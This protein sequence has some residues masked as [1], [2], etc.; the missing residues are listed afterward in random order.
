MEEQGLH[1]DDEVWSDESVDAGDFVHINLRLN[2]SPN[3]RRGDETSHST[4]THT[5]PVS[6]PA[7]S[8]LDVL[9]RNNLPPRASFFIYDNVND[10]LTRDVSRSKTLSLS[11]TWHFHLATSPFEVPSEFTKP[12][13]DAKK[14]SEIKVPGM[15]QMQGYGKGPWYVSR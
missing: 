7:W 3:N 12:G 11:G 6:L 15:W 4:K 9:H 2:K 10:A 8:N 5:F 13:F 1:N 14:W